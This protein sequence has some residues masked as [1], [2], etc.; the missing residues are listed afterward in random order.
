[1][2]A[3]SLREA[4]FQEIID[5]HDFFQGWLDGTLPK[6][7]TLF[8]RFAAANDPAFTLISPDGSMAGGAE[9]GAWIQA[10]H[11]TRP[12][13]RLWTDDHRM[14]FHT[15]DMAIVTYREWQTREGATSVRRSTAV[16]CIAPTA[17]NGVAW[18]HV[19]ETWLAQP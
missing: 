13:F 12:G 6:D 18:V 15:T 1:M 9:T 10:A 7:E 2:S 19:H 8:K 16:F 17:P 11:G 14:H 4:C 5:L 3:S